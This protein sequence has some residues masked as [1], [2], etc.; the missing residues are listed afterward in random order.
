MG[1]KKKGKAARSRYMIADFTPEEKQRVTNYCRKNHTTISSFL[2]TLALED[3][4]RAS[5][6]GP[7]EEEIDIRLRIPTEQSAKLQMFARLQGKSV[8]QYVA[9]LVT[10][11]LAKEK[12]SFSL[13]TESLRYYLSPEEHRLLKQ[14]L[15]SRK[16]S[17]RTYVSFLALKA[18]ERRRKKN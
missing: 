16:L 12:T 7:T 8:N 15:K 3:V 9:A 14:Y 6:E 5:R 10:P 4:Y 17:A 1:P 2:A 18:M 11:T 13:D